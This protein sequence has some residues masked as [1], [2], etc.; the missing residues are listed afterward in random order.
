MFD[1]YLRRKIDPPLD[2]AGKRLSRAGISANTITLA[3]FAAGI[4][5]AT[6]IALGAPLVGLALIVLNRLADG[7]DGAIARASER[8]DLGGYLDI[9]CDFLV[10][11]AIPFGFVLADPDAN[12]LA[13]AALLASFYA[14]GSTF[15]A[16]STLAAKRGLSTSAQG[17]KSLYYLGGIAEG[18]ETIVFFVVACLFADHFATLAW[19]FAAIC[20]FSALMRLINGA[21]MLRAQR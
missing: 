12:A 6:A 21:L 8:T 17:V 3:G 18:A 15:L 19:V 7:L 10:Y 2:A 16:F 9:V 11:G 14:S 13:G 20:T 5:A 4:V 1:A